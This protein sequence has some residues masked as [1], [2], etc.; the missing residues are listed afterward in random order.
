MEDLASA[1]ILTFLVNKL[2][3]L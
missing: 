2:K 3:Q 1:S